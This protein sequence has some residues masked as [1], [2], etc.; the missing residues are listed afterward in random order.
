MGS[1]VVVN[2]LGALGVNLALALSAMIPALDRCFGPRR[3]W[4]LS[5]TRSIWSGLPQLTR[6]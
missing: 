1:R 5:I 2:H 6:T 4:N 3:S